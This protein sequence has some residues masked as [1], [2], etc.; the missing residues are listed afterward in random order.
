MSRFRI[1]L[2]DAYLSTLG[3]G[4]NFL[5]VLCELIEQEFPEADV[6]VLTYAPYAVDIARLAERFGVELRRTR[7]RLIPTIS[8]DRLR[9]FPVLQR[10]LHERDLG[11]LSADYD[12]FVNNTIYSIA[13]AASRYSV[14]MCM[15]PLDPA[16]VGLRRPSRRRRL[17]APY[18]AARRALYH[19]WIGRYDLL[20]CNSEYTRRWASR[21][22]R[23]DSHVLYPPVELR[24]RL[25]LEGKT[26]SILSIGRF[27][28]GNHNKKHDI[29]INAFVTL[30]LL[31]LADWDLHLVGGRTDVAGTDEYI[32]DLERRAEG[33]PV[34]FHFDASRELLASLLGSASLFWQATGFEEDEENEP[35]KLEHFGV[36]TVEAMTHGC[37][38][39]VYRSGGQPEIIE[40]GATGFLWRTLPELLAHTIELAREPVERERMARAAHH[41]SKRYGREA[42]R[43][44]VR[45]LLHQLVPDGA[46]LVVG[47]RIPAARSG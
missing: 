22:W 30:R 25:Q 13:P 29:L 27:F 44:E 6:E 9:H 34:H 8:R 1:G 21:M 7:L 4:E 35:E 28:A 3:G 20:L 19:R 33:H 26:K 42:F 31:G 45:A 47:P 15:F 37:V 14:Y 36:S 17:L 40:Q 10:Y 46:A 38:P 32:A 16:P 2:F 18:V 43:R 5:A 24:P 41:A 39:L 12:L 11:R 23:L